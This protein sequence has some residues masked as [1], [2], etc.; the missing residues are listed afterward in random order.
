V[1]LGEAAWFVAVEQASEVVAVGY[2]RTS[3]GVAQFARLADPLPSYHHCHPMDL[4]SLPGQ[5]SKVLGHYP[6]PHHPPHS[7]IPPPR[8][9]HLPPVHFSHLHP[10]FQ[11]TKSCR[12]QRC[13]GYL[14][15]PPFIYRH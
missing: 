10:P 7:H 14:R 15:Y 6:H 5:L 2:A 12:N 9:S 3:L 11:S 1:V 13:L 4:L 8:P